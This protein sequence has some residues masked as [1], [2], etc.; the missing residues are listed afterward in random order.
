MLIYI[1]IYLII[2]LSLFF[3]KNRFLYI[4]IYITLLFFGG[5]RSINVGTD[6]SNYEDIYNII[7]SGEE[8]LKY[9]LAYVEP[10]W[11]LIN[12]ICGQIFDDYRPI[13]FIGVFLAIT[14]LFICLWKSCKNPFHSIFFYITL[15]F[16]YNSFNITRQM[17]AVSIIIYSIYYLFKGRKGIFYIGVFSAMLFHYSSILCFLFPIII[18]KTKLSILSATII[19]MFTYICGLYIIPK[20]LPLLPFIGRY[21][22]YLIDGESS[23]S[24]TRLLLNLFFI[25]ILA[26]CN[27]KKVHNYLKLFFIG[28]IIYNLFSFSSSVGRI[29]LY[30]MCTQLFLFTTMDSKYIVNN[31]I[32]KLCAFIYATTYYFLMLNANSGEIIPYEIWK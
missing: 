12:Y 3:K 31:Y 30:F 23:G 19:L 25:F 18:R 26:V 22:T 11:V 29:A 28:I 24:V 14:P 32:L 7:N 20:I 2:T 17:I 8:G 5:M 4:V 13:I 6:T 27:Y 1:Y 9:V 15:Y 10:G 16:Y 21:S